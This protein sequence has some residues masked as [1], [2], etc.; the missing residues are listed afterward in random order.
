MLLGL[1]PNRAQKEVKR[2]W[3][4]LKLAAPSPTSRDQNVATPVCMPWSGSVIFL[5]N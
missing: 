5:L 4:W 1:V 3:K 2:E